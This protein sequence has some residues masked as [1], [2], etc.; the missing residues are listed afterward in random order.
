[1]NIPPDGNEFVEEGDDRKI[2][3]LKHGKTWKTE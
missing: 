2:H 3:G 1:M